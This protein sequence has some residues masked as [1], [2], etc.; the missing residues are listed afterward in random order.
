MVPGLAVQSGAIAPSSASFYHERL[1]R[2]TQVRQVPSVLLLA[3]AVVSCPALSAAQNAPSREPAVT[4]AEQEAIIRAGVELH[5][6]GEYDQA[7]A[8]YQEVLA[9]SP[10][11]VTALFE[12]AY[13]Y[14]AKKDFDKTLETARKGAEFK[15]DLLPLFYDVMGSAFDSSGRPQQAID[16]Y[17]QGIALVPDAS[18]LYYNMAVTY[19]ESLNQPD[20]AR[21]ALEQ[22]VSLE[23]LHPEVQLLLGQLFQSSGYPGPAF[24]A[25]STFLVL[26]PGGRQAL[27][28]YGLWRALLKG[29]VDPIPSAADAPMRDRAVAR[30]MP[31]GS[32]NASKTDEGDFSTLESLLAPTYGAFMRKM[33]EGAPEIQALVAQVTDLLGALPASSSGPVARAFAVRHYLPFF[34]ELREQKYVEP[35]VYW[36]SQ[37]APVPGVPE[38]LKANESRVREFLGWASKY[39]WP[40]P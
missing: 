8:R 33:D 2:R 40:T 37:R 26:D 16:A 12:L 20:A 10:N 1:E 25:L 35:F 32:A 19:R 14:L 31:D 23:P 29:G 5:D 27:N 24:L 4:T 6:K 36:A 15:S 13:S 21:L 7:I 9:K 17:K 38:W 11:D 39:S 22:A 34:V 30:A 28:G 18:Q 3:V